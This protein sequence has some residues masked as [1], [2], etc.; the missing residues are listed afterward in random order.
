MSSIINK[1]NS[2]VDEFTIFGTK[3]LYYLMKLKF[4]HRNTEKNTT[5]KFI[6]HD[7]KLSNLSRDQMAIILSR[8]YKNSMGEK[9]D[10]S[11]P[12]LFTEKIQ[13]LKIYDN[14][15]IKV[16]LADKYSVRKW[17]SE[18][19]GDDY[20]IPLL[21][22]W[23]KFEDINFDLLPDKFCIKTNHGSGMNYVV[24]DKSAVDFN[25]VGEIFSWWLR[26]PFY[27]GSLELHYENIPRKI[28]AEKYIVEMDGGLY[29]Y[30]LHCFNGEPMF[31]QCIGDRNLINHTGYQMNFSVDWN[32][33]D[34]VFEDY[35]FFSHVVAK[36][37][38][39]TE[40]IDIAKIL[41]T[42]FRYVR[43]DLYEISG[44]VLFGEMTFTPASGIY[45]YKGTWTRKKNKELGDM[46]KLGLE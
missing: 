4:G 21:G 1:L 8:M 39:L 30:K 34:W 6:E 32:P 22:A 37:K 33:L 11:N 45:P 27:A 35:P 3:S 9:I 42:G 5:L 15:P 24:K 23:D 10:F 31:I 41:S 20:L 29:D 25:K 19:I 14:S 36:P 7:K 16:M 46:L 38:C 17:I 13:Y 26:R 2:A 43:V 40:M 12:T 44:K 18:K 28:I